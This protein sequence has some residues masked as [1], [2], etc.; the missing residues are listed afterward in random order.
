MTKRVDKKQELLRTTGNCGEPFLPTF[1]KKVAYR[2]RIII[3][4][5]KVVSLKKEKVLFF[6]KTGDKKINKTIA[7][8]LISSLN[9]WQYQP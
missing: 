3:I 4:I 6:S 8:I 2:K 1:R 5:S 7:K 9:S